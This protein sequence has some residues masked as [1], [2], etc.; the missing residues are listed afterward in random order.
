MA[1]IARE[2]GVEG[3]T[4]GTC[5]PPSPRYG[6]AHNLYLFGCRVSD[7]GANLAGHPAAIAAVAIFCA[8]WFV[9]GGEQGI[10]TLTLIL[11]VLAITLTQMVL[12][13]QRRSEDALHM[14]IDELILAKTGARD[15]LAGIERRT[16]D[17]LDALRRDDPAPG[18]PAAG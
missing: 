5:P 11:S 1:G 17:E 15:E 3:D 12:N 6:L 4:V 8:V 13:Q 2:T 10:N 7:A 9:E 18:E 16:Q 14:K